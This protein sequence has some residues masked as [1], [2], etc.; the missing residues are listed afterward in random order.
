MYGEEIRMVLRALYRQGWSKTALAQE[1]RL[2]WRTVD[3]RIKQD[4]GPTYGPRACPAELAPDQLAHVVRRLS[5]CPSIRSTTLYRDAVGRRLLDRHGVRPDP[6]L[7]R[8][9]RTGLGR[10]GGPPGRGGGPARVAA[11]R[12]AGSTTSASRSTWSRLGICG[13]MY[14]ASM[15]VWAYAATAS[16]I[17]SGGP[18]WMS[19]SGVVQSWP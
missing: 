2:N 18:W 1:F 3:R 7:R 8:R 19:C 4:A 14:S 12:Y 15:P 9:R 10:Q 13:T 6:G 5:A 16:P 17:A 11:Y